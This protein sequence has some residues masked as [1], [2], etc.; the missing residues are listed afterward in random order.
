MPAGRHRSACAACR[1]PGSCKG[2]RRTSRQCE[3]HARPVAL[4][5]TGGHAW[6][7][8]LQLGQLR[9]H[10]PDQTCPIWVVKLGVS[11]VEWPIWPRVKATMMATAGPRRQRELAHRGGQPVLE[12]RDQT[13]EVCAAVVQE[14]VAGQPAAP[15]QQVEQR[16]PAL[17]FA[18]PA[19]DRDCGTDAQTASAPGAQQ[20]QG[21][22]HEGDAAAPGVHLAG[23]AS[24]SSLCSCLCGLAVACARQWQGARSVLIT[25]GGHDRALTTYM[26]PDQLGAAT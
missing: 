18:L 26:A 8:L 13:Q 17:G 10:R 20:D 2:G 16:G 25:A 19:L 12:P 4:Q 24:V 15:L 21:G 9:A 6:C 14:G 11:G 1:V 5:R 7:A 22:H 23:A 3:A